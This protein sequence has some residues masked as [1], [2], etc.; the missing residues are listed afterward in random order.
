VLVALPGKARSGIETRQKHAAIEAIWCIVSHLYCQAALPANVTPGSMKLLPSPAKIITLM[1]AL[2][3]T[4]AVAL[5][6]ESWNNVRTL[7]PGTEVRLEASDQNAAR[8]RLASVTDDSV[9]LTTAKGQQTFARQQI[10]RISLRKDSHRARNAL[11]GAGIGAGAGLGVGL[12]AGRCSQF[13]IVSPGL[14]RGAL[15][16]T[17]A[18]VGAI[19][20]VVLPTGG[21]KEVYKKT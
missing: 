14:I 2:A 15:A 1:I 4:P 8:G 20:G 17:G 19:V 6:A 12:A 21:W 16:A 7:V 5:A 11:I 10:V 18:V 3:I 13:C 9:V